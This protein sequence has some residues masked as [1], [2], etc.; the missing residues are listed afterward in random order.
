[1][2]EKHIFRAY[3]IRGIYGEDFDEDGADLIGK[4]Y[5]K[6][7]R[8]KYPNKEH[9]TVVVSRD[10]RNSGSV[11]KSN[12]INALVKSG[13]DVVDAGEL[14]SP[15]LYFALCTQG[16]DGGVSITASHNSAPYNGFKLLSGGAHSICGEELQIIWEIIQEEDFIDLEN[17]GDYPTDLG[18][19][20]K[21]NIS[22][23]YYTLLSDITDFKKTDWKIAIDAGNGIAGAHY[24]EF[25]RRAGFDVTELYCDVDGNF[26]NHEA[27]PER[28]ENMADLKK[29]VLKNNLD[30]GLAYDGDGDR[31]GVVDRKGNSFSADLLLLLLA[32][33]LL[34]KDENAGGAIVYDL[35]STELL[36]EEIEEHGG[37]PV[38]CKTGH[39]FVEEEM[40]I[41]DAL[42]GGEVSGHIFM[43]EN[44][45]GFD[46]ALLASAKLLE[47]AINLEIKSGETFTEE[48]AKLP[49]TFVTPEEKVAVSES[50]KFG[51]LDK[52]VKNLLKKYPN[53][54]TMD[55]IR[56][57]FGESAWGIVR[58]SNTSPYL[59]TRF[60]ARSAKKLE[61]I[62]KIMM[63]VVAKCV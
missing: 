21:L 62:K 57:E 51:I 20:E 2:L 47:I 45:F 22:E 49:K 24:P 38:M 13:I 16:F 27:D 43:A 9:L 37:K 33:D 34:Q 1:M 59:T 39:S 3:D 11:L 15:M 8:K 56:I 25:F 4:G 10:G 35:K 44:Y 58:A 23:E 31:V 60:E 19:V 63:D 53:A 61:E 12:F 17:N 6:Y 28:E 40:E 14:P 7:L 41:H 30:F 26:P 32:R 46:D 42:L 29:L 36:K 54:L 52:I 50:K 18:T 48:F 5:A 55:G